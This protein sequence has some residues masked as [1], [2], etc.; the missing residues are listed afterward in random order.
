MD[1]IEL[2]PPL[3]G[4]ADALYPLLAGTSVCDTLAWDGP[5]SAEEFEQGLAL[6]GLQVLSGDKHFF[7]IVLRH[8][9]QPIGSCDLRFEGE[10]TRVANVGLW[11]GEPYQGRGYGTQVVAGLVDYGF[12]ELGLE[13]IEADIFVGNWASRRV[14]EKNGFQYEETQPDALVKHGRSVDEWIVGLSRENYRAAKAG[15]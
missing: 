13:K 4:D 15:G 12:G 14:F 1:D 10:A 5:E 11:I 3:P 6:R 2:R 9:D 7:T 8:S